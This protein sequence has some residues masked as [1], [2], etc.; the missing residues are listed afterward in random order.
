[1]ARKYYELFGTENLRPTKISQGGFK[2]W[3]HIIQ[4][5]EDQIS[6]PGCG[7]IKKLRKPK[8]ILL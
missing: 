2:P 5:L 4:K 7:I 6:Q 8:T 1:M 3:P